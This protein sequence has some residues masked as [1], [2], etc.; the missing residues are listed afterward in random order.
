[1]KVRHTASSAIG[2]HLW[3]YTVLV[4]GGYAA[5]SKNPA[6]K[7]IGRISHP[8]ITESSG[9]AASR[10]HPDVF[11][12]HNDGERPALYAIKRDGAMIGEFSV[13]GAAF[14]D[15]EDIA[16][17]AEHQLFLADTGNNNGRRRE[18]NVYMAAEPS[19]SAATKVVPILRKWV[20]RYPS[21]PFDSEGLFVWKGV[22]YLVS[23]V[24]DDQKAEIYRFTLES[25][26]AQK[27][28]FIARLNVE[29]PVTAADI[30]ADGRHL[31]VLAKAGPFVFTINGDVEKAGSQKPSRVKFKHDSM[32]GCC[33]VPGGLLTCAESRQIYFFS[34]EVFG[35]SFN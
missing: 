22:G 11:W 26:T 17:D 9:L 18:V 2:L 29:S 28:E 21:A 6:P 31:A 10:Q 23:K 34:Q 20:L 32:E 15:W 3:V 4:S 7:E 24:T 13:Q 1:M 16:L 25:V 33:F 19:P 27:L 35:L 12:T 30:S 14:G 5:E 8:Q